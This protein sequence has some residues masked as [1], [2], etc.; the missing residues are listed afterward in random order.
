VASAV[1]SVLSQ[2]LNYKDIAK[3]DLSHLKAI[4]SGGAPLPSGVHAGIK[5]RFQKN[6]GNGYG[7]SETCSGVCLIGNYMFQPGSVGFLLP[8]TEAIF[9]DPESGKEMGVGEKGELCLRGAT[10]MMGYLNRPEETARTIDA[11]GFFHTGDI[12]YISETG[13]IFITD[14]IKELIKYKG[15]QI[16]PA[17]LESL[18]MDHPLVADAAVVGIEDAK[19][20][21]EVPR[22]FIVLKDSFSARK[23]GGDR[24]CEEV[25]QW[26]AER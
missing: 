11:N 18:L 16:A 2:M 13:H 4:L 22:A 8:V 21:T 9:V 1:P 17:E 15:L 19:R 24:V 25:A 5:S 7:M 6:A 26:L 14:R 3:Y 10:V 12:G 20:N 23:A